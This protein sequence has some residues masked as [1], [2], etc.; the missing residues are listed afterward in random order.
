MFKRKSVKE[1]VIT[2][3]NG[4]AKRI[5]YKTNRLLDLSGDQHYLAYLSI[6]KSSNP[7][8]LYYWLELIL[9]CGIATFGLVLNSPAIIIGAM[10]IS[11]LMG[12]ILGAGLAL[13]A[14]DIFL[15][16]RSFINIILSIIASILGSALLVHFLP[17]KEL[18]PEILSR[19]QPT[20]LDLGVAIL[21]GFAAAF[22]T[23][24]SVKGLVTAIPGVAIAVALMPPLSVVGFGL[25]VKSTL[26]RW[27]EVMR[28]GGLLFAANFVAIVLTS[29][30]V[31]LI[32]NMGENKVKEGVDAWQQDP[33]HHTFLEAWLVKK[34]IWKRFEKIGTIQA[35]IAVILT[36][37]ILIYPPLSQALTEVKNQISL[38]RQKEAELK[39]INKMA[40]DFFHKPH[41]YEVDKVNL[42]ETPEK[43][44]AEVLIRASKLVDLETRNQFEALASQKLNKPVHLVLIQM[45][46]TFGND[47]A[48]DW[49]SLLGLKNES[50]DASKSTLSLDQQI[51][52]TIED[53]WPSNRAKLV[54]IAFNLSETQSSENTTKLVLTYLSEKEFS[55]DAQEIII[56]SLKRR[57]SLDAEILLR[58]LPSQLK[59]GVLS[60][61]QTQIPKSFKEPIMKGAEI[62]KN[63]PILIAKLEIG[64]KEDDAKSKL[65][66]I[67]LKRK[68]NLLREF[69]NNGVSLSKIEIQ[70]QQTDGEVF[71]RIGFP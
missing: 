37:I 11:P 64:L 40:H 54:G 24:K 47:E 1:K 5:N 45:P 69:K 63:N 29:M 71:L 58:W 70:N 15:G 32:V 41:L 68:E 21:C 62:L 14:G 28:G 9:S 60:S 13:A 44:N 38:K 49:A 35:R 30:L 34:N 2:K 59:L 57:F 4:F 33:Q 61:G 48:A 56:S 43:V 22:A 26:P 46:S 51:R 10:L 8:D 52:G 7:F 55:Q 31:F 65:K 25:G 16:I 27:F 66:E 23:L 53:L 20:T 42:K 67:F 12:P 18:T 50:V 6:V 17:F 3:V 39:M 19:I 36:F